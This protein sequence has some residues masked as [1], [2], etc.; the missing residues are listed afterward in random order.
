MVSAM[1]TSLASLQHRQHQPNLSSSKCSVTPSTS[2]CTVSDRSPTNE[3]ST[4][5]PPARSNS[6]LKL[7]SAHNIFNS[8]RAGTRG[9]TA[10]SL[11]GLGF[12][13]A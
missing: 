12:A 9:S 1:P 4:T 13:P 8:A 6:R 7:W 5:N 11:S 3:S 10:D 2:P